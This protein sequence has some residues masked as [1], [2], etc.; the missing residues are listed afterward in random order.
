MQI[1]WNYVLV[2]FTGLGATK[3]GRLVCATFLSPLAKGKEILVGDSGRMLLLMRFE[4]DCL[5]VM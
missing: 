2:W 4:S 3:M 5:L 1:W